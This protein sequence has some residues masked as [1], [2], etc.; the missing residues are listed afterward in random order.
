VRTHRTCCRRAKFSDDHFWSHRKETTT[1]CWEWQGRKN[2]TDGY[3]IFRE[4]LAHRHAYELAYGPIPTDKPCVLHRCDRPACFRPAHLFAGTQT[5]NM[6]DAYEKHGFFG[7]SNR[8]RGRP[9]PAMRVYWAKRRDEKAREGPAPNKRKAAL[10][11]GPSS[12]GS[13][14]H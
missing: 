13:D 8:H 11:G 12:G 4:R 3:G 5:D 10:S 6:R 1:G 14:G 7:Y 9:H 2:R